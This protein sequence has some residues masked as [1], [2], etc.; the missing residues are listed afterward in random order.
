M[1]LDTRFL[2]LEV[3]APWPTDMPE[4]RIIA[5]ESRHATLVFF[6]DQEV[7]TDAIPLPPFRLGL[8][9]QFVKP[10][11]LSRVVAWEPDFFEKKEELFD[12]QTQ[13]TALFG[14]DERRWL[15]HVTLARSPFD[16]QEWKKSFFSLPAVFQAIHLYESQGNLEYEKIW[17]YPLLPPF[18]EI[19][20]TADVA[21]KVRGEDFGTLYLH[22]LTA[23]AFEFPPILAYRQNRDFGNLNE[24]IAALGTALSLADAE[25]GAPLKAVSYHGE[26]RNKNGI[27]EWEMIV[28]V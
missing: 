12:Y 24:V 13:L 16:P 5:E 9:G 25:W 11:F 27:L 26:A 23:I 6:G 3:I 14:G 4:G 15:P 20:H 19:P 7:D 10:L 2:G 28:D 22:A 17:S 8:V 18:E 21:Y 1:R